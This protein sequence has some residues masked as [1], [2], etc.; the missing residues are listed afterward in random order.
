[1]PGES[2]RLV[3]I[4]ADSFNAIP[5]FRPI[6]VPLVRQHGE[7]QGLAVPTTEADHVSGVVLVMY[8]EHIDALT[9]EPDSTLSGRT[10]GRVVDAVQQLYSY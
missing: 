2:F 8:P 1:M 6:V 4:S 7:P 3:V 10:M 9:G 5:G